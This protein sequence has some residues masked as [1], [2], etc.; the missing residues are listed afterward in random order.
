MTNINTNTALNV[1]ARLIVAISIFLLLFYGT[2]ILT[3]GDGLPGSSTDYSGVMPGNES[4]MN[5]ST[6]TVSESGGDLQAVL[7]GVSNEGTVTEV[8][9]PSTLIVDVDGER[10]VVHVAS[11]ESPALNQS[12]VNTSR[13]NGADQACL[14]DVSREGVGVVREEAV[15]ESVAVWPAAGESMSSGEVSAYVYLGSEVSLNSFLVEN[16][17]SVVESPVRPQGVAGEAWS[18]K[19]SSLLS[20]QDY[21]ESAGNGLWSC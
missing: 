14:A 20:Y 13:Y 4:S 7:S 10:T 11:V 19:R 17:Y 2:V 3:E 6:P 9:S 1:I 12:E 21:A 15:G 16:G 18:E 5:T 8:V